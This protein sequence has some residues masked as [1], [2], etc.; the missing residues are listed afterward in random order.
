MA[1]TTLHYPLKDTIEI[2]LGASNIKLVVGCTNWY[3]N[4]QIYKLPDTLNKADFFKKLGNYSSYYDRI[5]PDIL[6]VCHNVEGIEEL[7]MSLIEMR[8]AMVENT[9]YKEQRNISRLEKNY[10]LKEIFIKAAA[11]I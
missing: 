4:L 8:Q 10:I 5:E 2:D 7:I 9:V 6:L 1:M 11:K 3:G